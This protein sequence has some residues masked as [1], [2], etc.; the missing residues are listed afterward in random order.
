VFG[1]ALEEAAGEE[2]DEGEEEAAEMV[3]GDEG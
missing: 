1:E 2:G 3:A